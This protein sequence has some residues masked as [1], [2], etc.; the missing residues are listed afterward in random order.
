MSFGKLNAKTIKT[1]PVPRPQRTRRLAMVVAVGVIAIIGTVVMS[2][3]PSGFTSHV[4]A[5]LSASWI[6]FA[7]DAEAGSQVIDWTQM[8]MAKL[9]GDQEKAEKWEKFWQ[10][11]PFVKLAIPDLGN[12]S[13]LYG[14][15]SIT[16]QQLIDSI[17]T[18]KDEFCASHYADAIESAQKAK[19]VYID[20]LYPGNAERLH[21]LA[22][23]YSRIQDMTTGQNAAVDIRGRCRSAYPDNYEFR[24]IC[25]RNQEEAR[26]KIGGM[27][28]PSDI[29]RYC[30]P[31]Y[32]DNYEYRL[33]CYRNQ[34][35]ARDR[36]GY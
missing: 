9:C 24:E 32:D 2:K 1:V 26:L 18:R 16:A 21:A 30:D 29:A 34:M 27:D 12:F 19:S 4:P 8:R 35:A 17:S 31:T 3:L 23:A 22:K 6:V 10:S 5:Q 11:E 25:E 20:R 7:K 28:V 13:N 14:D 36:L 15:T 33:I